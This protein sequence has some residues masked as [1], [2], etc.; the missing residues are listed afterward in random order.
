MTIS[1]LHVI[2][3]FSLGGAGRAL[4]DLVKHTSPRGI[5]HRIVSLTG[6]DAKA[7]RLATDAGAAC[8]DAADAG[9]LAQHIDAAD[10]VHVHFWNTPELYEFLRACDRPARILVW[11]AVA[12][13]SAPHVLSRALVDFADLAVA[14][15]PY[16]HRL[17]V[18]EEM[19]ASSRA[20]STM[21]IPPSA[22]FDRVD[23]T[24]LPHESFNVGYIGT[25]DFVKMHPHF[26]PMSARVRVPGVRFIVCGPG[27]ATLALDRQATR[28]HVRDLFEFRGYVDDVGG[29]LATLDV[30]GYPLCER[31]YSA[32]ELALQE[33]MYAGVP[34]VIFRHGGAQTTVAHD[35]TGL[36]VSTERE[37][38]QAIEHLYQHPAERRRLGANAARHAREAFSSDATASQFVSAYARLAALDKRSRAL[39][40]A[41]GGAAMWLDSLAGTVPEFHISQ[42]SDDIEELIDAEQIIGCTSP[43][44]A[45][46]ASGGVLHYR[47]RY[48]EDAWLRLWSG[49]IL[50][51]L[52]R[53]ALAAAEFKAA[54]DQGCSHWRVSWYLV[55]AAMKASAFD[56]AA[57]ALRTVV[58]AAPQ[59]IPARDLQASGTLGG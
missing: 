26:V 27:E 51:Q 15:C 48:P 16:T 7:V 13:D 58:T 56:L 52:G 30:F 44:I 32:T 21:M 14:S 11:S 55:Q 53:P 24:P 6:A 5:H 46:A 41:G 50:M 10:I 36:V 47:R 20:S 43:Q 59:F 17:P 35:E 22:D 39:R 3:Q 25:V 4:I 9:A 49:L 8:L 40:I 19:H 42:T 57:E 33:A 12:G 28:L 54:I 34:P 37:Y 23:V 18:F 29:V 31:N 45:A 2:Q 1:V 38:V